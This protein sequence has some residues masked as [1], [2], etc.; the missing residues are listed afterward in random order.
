ML[1]EVNNASKQ[2]CAIFACGEAALI[3]VFFGCREIIDVND[4]CLVV[5]ACKAFFQ[6]REV[7]V[8]VIFKHFWGFVCLLD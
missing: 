5:F 6:E 4:K 3:E 1:Y 7:A 8:I 2:V